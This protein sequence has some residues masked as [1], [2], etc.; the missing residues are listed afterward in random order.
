MEHTHI[1]GMLKD[2]ANGRWHPIVFEYHPM[3]DGIDSPR[4]KS[5]M[6]HT[7]GFATRKEAEEETPKLAEQAKEHL[8]GVVAV[9]IEKD[10]PWYGNGIPAMSVFVVNGKI[11]A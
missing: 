2:V 10:I 9:D 8:F 6:H 7:G 5:K 3:P 1:V 11:V 4:F